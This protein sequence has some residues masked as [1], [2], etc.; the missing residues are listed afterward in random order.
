MKICPTCQQTYA[1]ESLNFCLNDG[2]ILVKKDAPF[3]PQETVFMNQPQTTAPGKFPNPTAPANWG[4]N[5]PAANQ[6]KPKSRAWL[7]V[8]GIFGAV[9]LICGGGFVG[10]I[11]LVANNENKNV[12]GN[13]S[14]NQ[15]NSKGGDVF[16][17]SKDTLTDNLSKWK[18]T[19]ASLGITDYR[20][21]EFYMTSKPGGYYFVLQSGS[22]DFR[23]E[24]ATTKVSVRNTVG[25]A[26][27][28]G[29]GIMIHNNIAVALLQDYAFLIESSTQSYRVVKHQLRKE[30]ELVKWTFNNSVKTGTQAN[31]LE[32]RD[33]NG[34]MGFYING[35]LVTTVEDKDGIKSGV[36]GLYAGGAIP[37]AFKNLQ[38]EK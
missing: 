14:G 25:T 13:N 22:S 10:L 23:T 6:P 3:T 7:W 30:T 33:N 32:V 34:K 11:A 5:S 16:G 37:I 21:G 17:E 19:D 28:S 18:M 35:N 4:I 29:F 2:A 15:M 20:D 36:P 24:N 27:K 12:S 1:D 38:V 9:V 8:L 26:T 31:D